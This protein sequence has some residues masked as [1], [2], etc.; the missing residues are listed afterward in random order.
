MAEFLLIGLIEK[1]VNNRFRDGYGR[2]RR[3]NRL[4]DG[5]GRDRSNNRFEDRRF[6][7]HNGS[8]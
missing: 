8:V 6:R 4:K 2:S 3:H 5:Y 7:R 1:F